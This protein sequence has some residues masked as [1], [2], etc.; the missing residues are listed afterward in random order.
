[1]IVT[2]PVPGEALVNLH[3]RLKQIYPEYTPSTFLKG[4][5]KTVSHL[6]V[7]MESYAVSSPYSFFLQKCED[8]SYC[9]KICTPV[10]N[11]IQD[12]VIQKQP[13]PRLIPIG[14]AT[15]CIESK[16]RR[17]HPTTLGH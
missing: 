13:T 1:M 7:Y 4:H 11:R 15:D 10:E 14:K 5:L 9:D 8:I 6:A 2:P 12:F 17:N 3:D 16:P